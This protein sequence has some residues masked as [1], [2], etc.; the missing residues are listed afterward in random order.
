M[1][2]TPKFAT[3]DIYQLSLGLSLC[4]VDAFIAKSLSVP[5]VVRFEYLCGNRTK[6]YNI[7]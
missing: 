6:L 1:S 3:R 5:L 2:S 7:I 4:Y